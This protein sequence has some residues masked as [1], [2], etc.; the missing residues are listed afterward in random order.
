ML[1]IRLAIL[2]PVQIHPNR[3]DC[4]LRGHHTR[5]NRGIIILVMRLDSRRRRMNRK[6]EFEGGETLWV[7][8]MAV[9]LDGLKE[10]V[11]QLFVCARICEGTRCNAVEKGEIGRRVFLGGGFSGTC[12]LST[13]EGKADLTGVREGRARN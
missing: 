13:L 8:N 7:G 10:L 11:V 9:I 12:Q 5:L 6:S 4:I 1:E 2:L 3:T